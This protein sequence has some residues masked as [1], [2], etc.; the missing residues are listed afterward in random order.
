MTLTNDFF[1]GLL[2]KNGFGVLEV[3]NAGQINNS[4]K[5]CVFTGSAA[6]GLGD[7]DADADADAALGF[8]DVGPCSKK[9]CKEKNHSQYHQIWHDNVFN[10]TGVKAFALGLGLKDDAFAFSRFAVV[11]GEVGTTAALAVAPFVCGA[12]DRALLPLNGGIGWIYILMVA[13]PL[14]LPGSAGFVVAGSFALEGTGVA[15][16]AATA[17]GFAET[18]AGVVG[19]RVTSGATLAAV[20]GI[21]EALDEVLRDPASPM[22]RAHEEDASREVFSRICCCLPVSLARMGTRSSGMGLLS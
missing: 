16:I 11:V 14:V 10:I 7:A 20:C 3:C 1:S 13:F 17:R 6:L 8:G 5:R 21:R 9:K 19:L 4:S 18:F 12:G 2:P 15:V 22:A